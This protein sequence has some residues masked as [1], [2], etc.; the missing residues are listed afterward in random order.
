MR[1]ARPGSARRWRAWWRRVS[2]FAG[3]ESHGGGVGV[4]VGKA[5]GVEVTLIGGFLSVAIERGDWNEVGRKN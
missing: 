5:G 4:G 2:S 1:A 3:C